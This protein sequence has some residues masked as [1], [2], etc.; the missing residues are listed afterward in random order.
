VRIYAVD[1]RTDD[2]GWLAFTGPRLRSIVALND[3]L[4]DR[5]PVLVSWPLA[6][7]FPCVHD[8]ARVSAGVA[9]TPRTVLE[10]PRPWLT[11]DR[12]PEIGGTFAGLAMFG[13][14]NEVPSRLAGHPE[15]DW[16]SVV[17]SATDIARDDY[18]RSSSRSVVWGVGAVRAQRPER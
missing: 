13:D 16:G 1:D 3:F 9:Q 18:A 8:I 7:L 11:D 14:L 5:G 12:N 6:F 2:A 17:V 4:A 15:V 10:S